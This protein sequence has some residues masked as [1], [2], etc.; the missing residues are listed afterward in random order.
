MLFALSRVVGCNGLVLP[1]AGINQTAFVHASGY[2]EINHSL[3]PVF[4]ELLVVL[5]ASVAVGVA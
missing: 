5:G 4:R 3:G 1:V 2:Q